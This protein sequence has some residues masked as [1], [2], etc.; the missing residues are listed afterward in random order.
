MKS[1][2]PAGFGLIR[3]EAGVVERRLIEEIGH[4]V[5]SGAPDQRRD[6]VD[7]QSKPI[8]GLLDF[9]K[10]LLQRLLCKVLL[11]DIDMRSNQFDHFTVVTDDRMPD[12][13]HISDRTVR[14]N[15][16]VVA[17]EV[18]FH[19]DSLPHRFDNPVPVLVVNT[20]P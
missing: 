12:G 19:S 11:G 18:R 8:L 15:D 2:R 16:A 20:I 13:M 17:F 3:C 7:D 10:R 6:R 14:K 1:A 9:V 4:P 5:W